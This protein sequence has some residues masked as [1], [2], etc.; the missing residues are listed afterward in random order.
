[1]DRPCG[2]DQTNLWL[3]IVA[4]VD[5]SV[6]MTNAGLASVAASI[7]SLFVDGQQLG[8]VSNYPRTTR[9]GIVTYSQG[10][11][12][13]ADLN[14]FTSI[15]QLNE[16][17]F[18]ILSKVSKS[19]DSYL[20]DGLDAA[21]TLLQE[22]SFNT[23]RGHYKKMV[24]VYASEY[25]GTGTQDPLPLATRMKQTVSIATVAY[26]Q[27]QNHGFLAEL[28]KI[29]TPGYSF[30]N[31]NG[32]SLLAQLRTAM[33][34]INCYCPNTWEQMRQSYADEN[35]IKYGVCLL[36]VT[37]QATWTAAKFSCR[38]HW[39]G[40]YLVNEYTQSKH[41][42]VRQIVSNNTLFTQPYT[43]F[44]GLSYV[45]GN[46][47]WE[48]PD[49]A[50]PV[51]LQSWSDW[52]PGYPTASST[53]TVGINVQSSSATTSTGWQNTNKSLGAK[54]VCEVASCDST[55]YCSAED[56]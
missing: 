21:D 26:S 38:N 25:K 32:D 10:A 2:E 6:G 24:I 1:M 50:S 3:D 34:Q 20:R 5:N 35:S 51:T 49:G 23:A 46:W 33:L 22:Q 54:Y 36:P 53:A 42:Y 47:Q 9:L 8:I 45:N 17:I 12:V 52:N 39:N 56:M 4:V 48:Q 15:E 16:K 28:S 13:V 11:Q 27:D 41:D 55:N 19:Q 30:T 18:S 40:A 44:I 43:Y 29:A 37:I 31:D 7:G 14:N